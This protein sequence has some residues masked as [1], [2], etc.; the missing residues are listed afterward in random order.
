MPLSLYLQS[1]YSIFITICLSPVCPTVW[2]H[3]L[4]LGCLKSHNLCNCALSPIWRSRQVAK[5]IWSVASLWGSIQFMIADMAYITDS[6]TVSLK[7]GYLL[8]Q[9][10][11]W[12]SFWWAAYHINFLTTFMFVCSGKGVIKMIIGLHS[13]RTG[14]SS[15]LPHTM[16]CGKLHISPHPPL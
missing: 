3:R 14:N 15:F 9:S 6:Q 8:F 4:G 10:R 12:T 13:L 2:F 11:L 16:V 1:G 5:H 7:R